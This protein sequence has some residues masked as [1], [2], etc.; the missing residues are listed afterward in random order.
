MFGKL[1]QQYLDILAAQSTSN[2]GMVKEVRRYI[3]FLESDNWELQKKIDAKELSQLNEK[4][5][6]AY[7]ETEDEL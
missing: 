2:A 1:V 5:G 3:S 7:F 4:F 6:Y